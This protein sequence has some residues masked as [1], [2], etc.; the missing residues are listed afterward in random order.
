MFEF[1]ILYGNHILRNLSL[2]IISTLLVFFVCRALK[3]AFLT[4]LRD[5]PGPWLAKFTRLWLFHAINSQDFEKTDIL[6]HRKYGHF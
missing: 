3:Q 4:P 5:V 6:L 1:L 2:V